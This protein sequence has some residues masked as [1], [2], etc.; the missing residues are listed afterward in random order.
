MSTIQIILGAFQLLFAALLTAAIAFQSSPD[1]RGMGTI[2]GDSGGGFFGRGKA[3]TLDKKL[4]KATVYL[5]IGFVILTIV[6]GIA[7]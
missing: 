7:A 3:K 2:T 6:L 5:S 4:A 1:G